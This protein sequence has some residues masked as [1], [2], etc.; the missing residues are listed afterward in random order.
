VFPLYFHS[1]NKETQSSFSYYFPFY[2]YYTQGDMVSKHYLLF[3]LYSEYHDKDK[4]VS[5][6]DILWPLIHYEY[7]PQYESERV[8]P[9]YLHQQTG[10]YD[11]KT[12]FPVYWHYNDKN[13]SH[14][15]FIPFYGH[16]TESDWYDLKV[17]FGPVYI[18][19][20]DKTEKS[21][22][23]NVMF[24]FYRQSSYGDSYNSYL[25][26]FYY[27]SKTP[28]QSK[29]VASLCFLPPYLY[30]HSETINGVES[31]SFNLWPF[32]GRFRNDSNTGWSVLWPLLRSETDEKSIR[33]KTQ[34]FNYYS[35]YEKE[36]SF[37]IFFPLWWHKIND[38][39]MKLDSVLALYHYKKESNSSYFNFLWLGLPWISMF[40]YTVDPPE[41]KHRL[42]P[43]YTYETYN[44]GSVNSASS[45]FNFLYLGYPRFSMFNYSNNSNETSNWLFPFYV[46][47]TQKQ[48]DLEKEFNFAYLFVPDVSLF[49]YVTST[50]ETHHRLFPLYTYETDNVFNP[51]TEF[52]LLYLFT[53]KLSL[54]NYN[55]NPDEHGN[56]LF[57][58]YAYHAEKFGDSEKDFNFAYLIVPQ[59]SLFRH[60]KSVSETK[61]RLFPVYTYSSTNS[62]N[63][64]TEFSMVY[65]FFPELNL[66]KYDNN[67][68]IMKHRLFPLYYYWSEKT[69]TRETAVEEFR[70]L[71]RL[72]RVQTTDTTKVYEFNP[73]Y[74][75][76]YEKDNGSYWSILGGLFGVETDKDNK[77]KIRLF[78]GLL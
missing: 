30:S 37:T 50:H 19:E 74:Y 32:Y 27:Y 15:Y 8:L 3:P 42:F 22:T 46:Y 60:T 57:P 1:E 66:F 33:G 7:A 39:Y 23:M 16:V 55:D 11:F 49:K 69:G 58:V 35:S 73:L 14:T 43:L 67:S 75:Y 76:E 72:V 10:D 28:E 26:P 47:S 12:F 18:A 62:E 41:L 63:P 20:T 13:L 59:V 6:L 71:W 52:S 36:D 54:F 44:S 4:S 65:L 48:G 68:Q 9:L 45:E 38:G 25:I 61:H 24:P 64:E 2:G 51:V 77:S 78:W 34:I 5:S 70:L 40:N 53:P 21:S 31:S 29:L 56:W 17:I